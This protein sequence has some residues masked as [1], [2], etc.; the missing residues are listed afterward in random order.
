MTCMDRLEIDTFSLDNLMARFFFSFPLGK[1]ICPCSLSV[2]VGA[3]RGTGI[4]GRRKGRGIA[5]CGCRG[6]LGERALARRMGVGVSKRAFRTWKTEAT[7]TCGG[8]GGC[9]CS[10]GVEVLSERMHISV[11]ERG[12]AGAKLCV[13]SGDARSPGSALVL[14]ASSW[15]DCWS[16]TIYIHRG[17]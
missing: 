17:L 16:R 10:F 9:S 4:P 8:F 6:C 15:V 11:G 12:G 14:S 13:W 1:R 7:C 2:R 5:L 3:W